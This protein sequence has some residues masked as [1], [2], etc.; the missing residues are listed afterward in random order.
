MEGIDFM[1]AEPLHFEGMI[2]VPSAYVS[3]FEPRP[4]SW[5]ERLF[6]KPWRPWIKTK[7]IKVS[8]L[9]GCGEDTYVCSYETYTNIARHIE[10][11]KSK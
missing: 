6:E 1:T 2:I 9:I 7:S 4:R 5:K 3:D 11:N 10:L 8:R